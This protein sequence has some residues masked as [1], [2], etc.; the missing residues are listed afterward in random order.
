MCVNTV[1][2][3]ERLA[4]E[5]DKCLGDIRAVVVKSKLGWGGK[6]VVKKGVVRVDKTRN[7]WIPW[8]IKY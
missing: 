4:R 1:W 7:A 8:G 3:M 5:G 2:G 6:G